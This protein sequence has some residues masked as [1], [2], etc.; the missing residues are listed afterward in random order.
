MYLEA[1]TN[2]LAQTVLNLFIQATRICGWPS[3]VR[4]D[5]GGE[6]VD[7]ARAQ[8]MCRGIGRSSHIAGSSV[9]NQQIERL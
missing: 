5:Q 7:V 1:S 8:I 2:N 6:N 9:H 4:S 3:R